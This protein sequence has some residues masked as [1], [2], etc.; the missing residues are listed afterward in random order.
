MGVTIHYRG[1]LRSEAHLPRL[2]TALLPW[3]KRWHTDLEEIDDPDGWAFRVRGNEV[4]EFKG[5]LHGFHLHPHEKA[6]TLMFR[7]SDDLEMQESCKTQF[8]TADVHVGIIELLM[9][10]KPL[11]TGFKVKDDGGYW[12]TGDREELERRMG[13]LN[14]M[15]DGLAKAFPPAP[16]EIMRRFNKTPQSGDN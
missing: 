4:Y 5:R 14:R 16:D 13:L 2:Q 1:K 15:I 7:V 12:D 11:F 3:A 6:E 8:A 9:E 10:I